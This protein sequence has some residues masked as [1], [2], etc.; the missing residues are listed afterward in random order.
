MDN[1]ERQI[2]IVIGM[3][4]AGTHLFE[5]ADRE[6]M[7]KLED[8]I[9]ALIDTIRRPD[10]DDG[11]KTAEIALSELPHLKA[12]M[13]IK[14]AAGTKA[15]VTA[16][17]AKKHDAGMPRPA[18]GKFY[19][20]GQVLQMA[21]LEKPNPLDQG[22]PLENPNDPMPPAEIKGWTCENLITIMRDAEGDI[23]DKVRMMLKKSGLKNGDIAR[24]FGKKVLANYICCYA[25]RNIKKLPVK[26]FGLLDAFGIKEKDIFPEKDVP[27]E[28]PQWLKDRKEN[29]IARMTQEAITGRKS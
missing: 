10:A 5:G 6:F 18:N 4:K 26:L 3:V 21:G 16:D 17:P 22:P 27:K 2:G 11:T 20:A 12:A 13:G 1:R 28:T 23:H 14:A 29:S 9:A 19:T 24:L 7:K 15:M 25:S 8:E